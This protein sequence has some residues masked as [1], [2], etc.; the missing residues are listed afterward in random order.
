MPRTKGPN[1]PKP[2][3]VT[4]AFLRALTGCLLEQVRG[5]GSKARR[6]ELASKISE[7][8]SQFHLGLDAHAAVAQ[9]AIDE[10]NADSKVASKDGAALKRREFVFDPESGRLCWSVEE[11][12]RV[13]AVTRS[14]LARWR[15]LGQGPRAIKLGDGQTS[16]VVYPIQDVLEWLA[17]RERASES[18]AA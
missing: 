12:A 14:R 9:I 11:T 5:R 1:D 3:V 2:V 6:N 16:S 8:L 13:L 18:A 15:Y 4:D 10:L 17:E 7:L